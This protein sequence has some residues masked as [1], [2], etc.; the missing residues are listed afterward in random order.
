M[1]FKKKNGVFEGLQEN[2][3]QWWWLALTYSIWKHRNNIIFSNAIFNA[4]K[5][6]EDAVFLLWTWL[7]CLEKN[8]SLHFN[9]WSSNL[10][11]G[12][13]RTAAQEYNLFPCSIKVVWDLSACVINV[14]TQTTYDMSL[15]L[16]YLVPLVRIYNILS[17]LSKKKN[18]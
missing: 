11:T 2:R 16:Y 13:L 1:Q 15:K 4:H 9:Q 12:F 7:R 14:C 6:M 17:L 18:Q 10:K 8:F 3:W 5:L